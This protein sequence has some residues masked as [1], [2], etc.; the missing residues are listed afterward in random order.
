MQNYSSMVIDLSWYK[1]IWN[2]EADQFVTD[3][4]FWK[5]EKNCLLQKNSNIYIALLCLMLKSVISSIE[6]DKSLI[7][8]VCY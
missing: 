6:I 1:N 2:T 3:R 8:V 4:H 7:D 5:R